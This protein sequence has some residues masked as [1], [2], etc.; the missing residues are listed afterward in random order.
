M[1]YLEAKA[2][3]G[4]LVVVEES[5]GNAYIGVADVSRTSITIH[6]GL[7][8]RPPVIALDDV[9]DVTVYDQHPDVLAS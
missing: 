5:D 6:T 9:D 3:D 7:A 2:L 1:Q 4:L 8:G